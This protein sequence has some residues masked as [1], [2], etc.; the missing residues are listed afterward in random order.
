MDDEPDKEKQ[1]IDEAIA[2]DKADEAKAELVAA[3]KEQ[4][5]KLKDEIEAEKMPKKIERGGRESRH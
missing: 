1:K 5:E 3:Q 4:L 2:K